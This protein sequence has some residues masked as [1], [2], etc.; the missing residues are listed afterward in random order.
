MSSD[1]YFYYTVYITNIKSG[2]NKF[3]HLKLLAV[4]IF[5]IPINVKLCNLW[6]V[7]KRKISVS[8]SNNNWSNFR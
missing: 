7:I 1:T 6:L 3:G 2:L 4:Y 8:C 5:L